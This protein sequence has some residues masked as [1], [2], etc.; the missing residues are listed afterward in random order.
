MDPVN[1][2]ALFVN[3]ARNTPSDVELEVFVELV[4]VVEVHGWC[5]G[6]VA[7]AD[8]KADH[9]TFGVKVA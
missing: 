7:V 4:E 6:A 9:V 8:A 5:V 3:P 1:D 2:T